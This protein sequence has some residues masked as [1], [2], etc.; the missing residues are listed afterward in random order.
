MT[1]YL[2]C[3]PTLY[4]VERYSTYEEALGRKVFLNIPGWKIYKAEL[5]EEQQ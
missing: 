2:L 4:T 5:I 1:C 3:S